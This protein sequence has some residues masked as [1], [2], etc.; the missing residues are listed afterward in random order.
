[1]KKLLI[2]VPFIFQI[3]GCKD[4]SATST[5]VSDV[6]YEI[7]HE[8]NYNEYAD[9]TSKNATVIRFQTEYKNELIKRTSDKVKAVNFE[10]EVIF[11]IDMGYRG[12][13]GHFIDVQSFSEENGYIRAKVIHT[14]PGEGCMVDA[15]ITN[16]FK[17]IKLKTTK[18]KG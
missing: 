10:E 6:E 2:L 3:Q 18:L 4:V 5:I 17:F 15:S 12:S 7:L 8:D 14:V 16:P 1:M 11:L 9:F 13:G